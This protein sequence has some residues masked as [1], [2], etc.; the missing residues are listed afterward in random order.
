MQNEDN[1]PI[2]SSNRGRALPRKWGE[3]GGETLWHG[4]SKNRFRPQQIFSRPRS[5]PYFGAGGMGA[6]RPHVCAFS[7]SKPNQR[8]P[9]RP[10]TP[11]RDFSFLLQLRHA[12]T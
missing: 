11:S 9:V 8:E 3:V 2:P 6:A 12:A 5:G 4:K 7:S 10:S 1:A